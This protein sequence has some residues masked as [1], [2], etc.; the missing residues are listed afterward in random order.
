[1]IAT[2]AF[3][4][5][6]EAFGWRTTLAGRRGAGGERHGGGAARRLSGRAPGS[7]RGS[8]EARPQKLGPTFLKTL[9]HVFLAA[10]PA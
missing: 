2:P 8:V 4:A 5:C 6:N 9:G 7:P 1:M 10:R 3:H